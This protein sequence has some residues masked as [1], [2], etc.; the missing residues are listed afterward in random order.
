M[1]KED[2]LDIQ[3]LLTGDVDIF[4]E[5]TSRSL[6]EVKNYQKQQLEDITKY[7]I[8]KIK[9]YIQTHFLTKVDNGKYSLEWPRDDGGNEPTVRNI[10]IYYLNTAING[11]DINNYGSTK[12]MQIKNKLCDLCGLNRNNYGLRILYSNIAEF[13]PYKSSTR[14]LVSLNDVNNYLFL[15]LDKLKNLTK[16]EPRHQS[17]HGNIGYARKS[18][19][20]W[21]VKKSELAR[22]KFLSLMEEW[23]PVYG[24]HVYQYIPKS[25]D[26]FY[27]DK[28]DY[29][30]YN[31]KRFRLNGT[32]PVFIETENDLPVKKFDL[33]NFI[34]RKDLDKKTG[35]DS[36]KYEIC[37]S[38]IRSIV[39]RCVEDIEEIIGDYG[40][41]HFE[42]K[43]T[44]KS[45]ESFDFDNWNPMEDD[46][47]NDSSA[48]SIK[49]NKKSIKFKHDI[50]LIILK[51]N[52]KFE[53]YLKTLSINSNEK[54][55][56]RNYYKKSMSDMVPT[57][58]SGYGSYHVPK[59]LKSYVGSLVNNRQFAESYID[60]TIDRFDAFMEEYNETGCIPDEEYFQESLMS[61]LIKASINGSKFLSDINAHTED[62]VKYNNIKYKKNIRRAAQGYNVTDLPKE[63]QNRL[64]NIVDR[65]VFHTK[66]LSYPEY[67]KLRDEFS[68]ITGY[69]RN[70][71]IN[72]ALS[73]LY[74]DNI[75]DWYLAS[76]VAMDPVK[77]KI[78]T[79]TK[80][81]HNTMNGN[82]IVKPDHF[83]STRFRTYPNGV[84]V[85]EILYPY[86]RLYFY[87]NDIGGSAI[88]HGE[89]VKYDKNGKPIIEDKYKQNGKHC[90][91]YTVKSGD[92][93]FFDPELGKNA[94]FM[95]ITGPIKLEKLY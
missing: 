4:Q 67:K 75:E 35:Y 13:I 36:K 90:Y 76:T 2:V 65:M 93:F 15:H 26:K 77:C 49:F 48:H 37:R 47:D 41:D 71:V 85:P 30:S 17:T 32:F 45:N 62:G 52:N 44:N 58:K 70:A 16:L 79:G 14:D 12:M 59:S 51:T 56:L 5:A 73:N 74:S 89:K 40:Y 54:N 68:K 11:Y 87:V 82:L 91:M 34:N 88:M 57:L 6:K 9:R 60:A 8:D 25:T 78:K 33:S 19:F 83:Y 86:S 64:I 3:A 24:E 80:L 55:E 1:K 94:V 84:K 66:Q 72:P 63:T 10:S 69:P 95:N 31:L 21:A 42:S 18:V 61:N 38:D 7:N 28:T 43:N 23:K 20:L 53:S 92:D 22:D 39:Q 46:Y 27:I 50:Q 29:D 81:F